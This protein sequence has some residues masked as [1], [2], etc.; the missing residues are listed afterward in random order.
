M[1]DYYQI[2]GVRSNATPDQI[3]KAFKKLA[4]KYHPDKGGSEEQFKKINDAYNALK[5][6]N[7][8]CHTFKE[9]GSTGRPVTGLNVDFDENLDIKVNLIVT[10]SD[11]YKGEPLKVS[12]YRDVHCDNCEGTG[13]DRNSLSFDCEICDGTGM[14]ERGNKCKYCQGHGIIYIGTCSV[15]EGN[16]IINKQAE[17]LLYSVYKI[18]RSTIK[19]LKEYG[20]QSKYFREKV[21]TLTLNIT[22]FHDIKY[23]IKEELSKNSLT[24]D[25]LYYNLNLN[26]KD[27][28][29]G[30]EY[31]YTTLD[32]K[33][34]KI[35]IPPKTKDGDIIILDNMGLLHDD[36]RGKLYIKINIVIDY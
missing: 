15:C 6:N 31:E 1:E 7:T 32:D 16:K 29:D 33:K 8:V 20:N 12:Y 26:Y 17:F 10:L 19:Y 23:L 13:F 18:R 34:V 14:D 22:Y 2:L 21:G 5:N 27:A 36:V 3:K 30:I 28:I 35:N 9:P 11:V 24:V 25:N 4:M